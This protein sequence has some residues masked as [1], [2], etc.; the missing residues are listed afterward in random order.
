MALTSGSKL[1]PY[2]VQCLLGV[3][4]MGEV[5]RA[6]D[7]RLGRDVALKTLP[8]A[9]VKDPERMARFEREAHVLAALNHPNIASIYGLEESDGIRALVI[10]LAEGPTLAERIASGPIAMEEAFRIASEV[11][12]ALEAA[13]EK[14]IIH[15]DLKPA[16]IKVALEG[17]IKVLDFGLAKALGNDASAAGLSDSP[18]MPIESTREGLI[19]GTAAY[20]SPEQARG[21]PLDKRSDIW[22][23]G[24]VLYEA[25]TGRK[26]FPGD[27]VTDILA[28][29]IEREPDWD[30]LPH[31]TPDTIRALLRR[32]LQKDPRQRQHD[33]ADARIEIEET[34]R[35]PVK[36][37]P[38]EFVE[39]IAGRGWP[40]PALLFAAA[41]FIAVV[42]WS[43]IRIA[44]GRDANLPHLTGVARL[45]HDPDFS[46]W[47]T[48][49]PDGK[50]LA[51]SSNRSGNYEIYV[52]RIEG[53]LEVNVTND[54]GQDFQPDFSPDGNWIAFVSTRSSRTGMVKIGSVGGTEFRTVGGDIWVVP[55]L[56]G[57]ARLLARDG[58]FPVWDPGGNKVVYVSG[59][60]NHRALLEV[61]A[62]GGTPRAVLPSESSSWEI[63]RARYSPNGRW[64]TFETFEGQVFLLSARGGS[65]SK[66][67]DGVSHVWDP[68]GQRIYYCTRLPSGGTR[69]S[70]VEIN[71]ATGELKGEPRTVSLLT[72]LLKDLAI[73]RDGRQLAVSEMEG[74]LNLTQLPLRVNG[75][76]PAAP[77]EVLS[78]GQVFDRWPSISPDGRSIAYVSNRLG[79]DELW[80]LRLGTKRLDRL[81]L[82]G[83]DLAVNASHWF[84]DGQRLSV[85]RRL[86][87]GKNS[88]WI[89]AADGSHGEE[90]PIPSFV[91]TA[92]SF[93]VSPDGRTVTYAALSGGYL[94]IFGFDL[95]TRQSH[96]LT[97]TA[98][99]KYTGSWSPNGRWLVYSSN[100]GG[101]IQLWRIG[102]SGGNP[103]QL[104]KGDDRIRHVFY[105]SD[106]RWLYYQPNHL[107]IYRMPAQGG[108]A[109]QVTRFSESGLF[110]EEPTISPDGR[111]L[112]YCRSNGGS[113]LW[114]LTV[115]T[116]R[117]ERE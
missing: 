106:G 34:L 96:Q 11:A 73:S 94:Q 80:I 48:W 111:Y 67:I 75:D 13:H 39:A 74:S 117:S 32:C 30:G 1:G 22:S 9:F 100:A 26:A 47:P 91:S 93:P 8:A 33:I 64:I 58:N 20:M 112:V 10:E 83:H 56:G 7:V 116:G 76:A 71:E 70:S 78:S 65:P 110:I 45:T 84:P 115:G 103:E 99:D 90:L 102:S 43:A 49:S 24:C 27:T 72:G 50:M 19:L 87:D 40:L 89:V 86:P 23:F 62:D 44:R 14:G 37:A 55:A 42:A 98:G 41:L 107:N 2:E 61:S 68:S 66:L 63:L 16:N 35:Q 92:D 5:Y 31:N 85:L 82:P 79:H 3:G 36:A 109:Q 51:F 17:K 18:T 113:S 77:E 54:P 28:A 52:R 57:Q 88:L 15:R 105:S 95:V 53:G 4:G 108:P 97:S 12:R 114:L 101:A 59:L 6:R 29:V 46:E 104:T 60:E 38:P 25:V 21:K 81:E 69:L